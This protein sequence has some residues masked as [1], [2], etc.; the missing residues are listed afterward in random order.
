MDPI[1]VQNNFNRTQD[2]RIN[3]QSSNVRNY[4]TQ[5]ATPNT[6]DRMRIPLPIPVKNEIEQQKAENMISG[7][8]IRT[9]SH[10]VQ[11]SID[12][13]S[14]LYK[15][16]NAM[17]MQPEVR[18]IAYKGRHGSTMKAGFDSEKNTKPAE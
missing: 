2:M 6:T 16:K 1:I 18:P 11:D 12:R 4:H 13:N 3:S 10:S 15:L 9:A 8:G 14:Q 7:S 5:V 17:R